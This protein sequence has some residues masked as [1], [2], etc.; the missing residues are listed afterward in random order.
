M[1]TVTVESLVVF[2]LVAL[3]VRFLMIAMEYKF[4]FITLMFVVAYSVYAYRLNFSS[5]K[6]H[7]MCL[8]Q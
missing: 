1:I 8:A 6:C 3:T 4:T 2:S 7:V 5:V